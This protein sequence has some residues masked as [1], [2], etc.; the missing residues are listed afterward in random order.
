[1]DGGSLCSDR[2]NW[3]A[4]LSLVAFHGCAVPVMG[5]SDRILDEVTDWLMALTEKHDV[6]TV[7]AL[8]QQ[9]LPVGSRLAGVWKESRPDRPNRTGIG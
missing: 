9:W 8:F 2:E 7:R 3:G 5:E 6:R 1:M 4:R